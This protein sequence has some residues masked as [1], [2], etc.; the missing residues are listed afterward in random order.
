VVVVGGPGTQRQ[1]D[2]PP[3]DETHRTH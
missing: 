1:E 2:L 3:H